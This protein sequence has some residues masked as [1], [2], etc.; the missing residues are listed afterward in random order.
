MGS[1]AYNERLSRQRAQALKQ[2][3]LGLDIREG[4]I[5]ASGKGEK[6]P[7]VDNGTAKNRAINRRVELKLYY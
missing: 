4:R 1:D 7:L 2:Y 5:E 3:L 6:D